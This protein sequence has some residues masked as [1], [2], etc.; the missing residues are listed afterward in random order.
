VQEVQVELHVVM[1][2]RERIRAEVDSL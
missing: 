2:S 1:R